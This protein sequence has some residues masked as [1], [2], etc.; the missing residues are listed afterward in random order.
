MLHFL[1]MQ[2]NDFFAF[3]ITP[4][5]IK[6]KKVDSLLI[7]HKD[8]A[9]VVCIFALEEAELVKELLHHMLSAD[10]LLFDKTLLSYCVAG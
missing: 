10:V 3:C 1:A 6:E 9:L 5:L 2:T 8:V 4:P 7:V